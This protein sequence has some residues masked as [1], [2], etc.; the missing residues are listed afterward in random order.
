M[1]LASYPETKVDYNM[2]LINY[3]SWIQT[4]TNRSTR[5]NLLSQQN[6][7]NGPS[8]TRTGTTNFHL[9][10]QVIYIPGL[11]LMTRLAS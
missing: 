4:S 8:N 2:N 7:H 9:T 5:L 3:G 11:L 6:H 10:F 1:D